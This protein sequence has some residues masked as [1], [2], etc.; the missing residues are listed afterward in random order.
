MPWHETCVMDERMAFIVDWQREE[1]TIAAL[2]RLYGVS[3]KTGY[4]WIERFGDEGIEGLNDRSR[5]PHDHPNA[6]EEAEIAAIVAVRTKHPTWGPKKIKAWLAGRHAHTHW[7]AQS[8]IGT[9]LERHGLVKH[10]RRR[11]HVPPNPTP[12]SECA[13][14]NDVWA[15][16]FKG[17][18][19][20]GDGWRF[21]T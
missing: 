13:A 12:L 16:D 10:R 2:C 21:A 20:T 15:M 5:A 9:I 18:F 8:V 4:K 3:R 1:M 6:V 19:R 17:W 7:P 11:R 14:A